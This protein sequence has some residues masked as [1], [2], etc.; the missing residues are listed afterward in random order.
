LTEKK[1]ISQLKTGQMSKQ[2]GKLTRY[3]MSF[4]WQVVQAVLRGD[5]TKESAKGVY[6]IKSN[7]AVLEWMR[8]FSGSENL[9][10][11]QGGSKGIL[12]MEVNNEQQKLRERIKQLE[13]ELRKA[14]LRADLWQTMIEVAEEH[15]KIDIKKKYGA[16]PSKP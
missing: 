15:L 12:L 14:N 2:K 8:K 9:S 7:S 3:S 16:Q 1:W 5:V 11:M 10:N 4:K 6:G 13:E